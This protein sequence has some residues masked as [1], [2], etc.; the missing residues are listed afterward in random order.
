M[1]DQESG[2]G[3]VAVPLLHCLFHANQLITHVLH[4]VEPA[5]DQVLPH[6]YA[7]CVADN[8]GPIRGIPAGFFIKTSGTHADAAF[9]DVLA[10]F[11]TVMFGADLLAAWKASFLPSRIGL[12]DDAPM[13]EQEMLRVIAQQR[14]KHIGAYE[15]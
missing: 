14:F 3:F 4:E 10:K 1:Q 8:K 11:S 6:T 2:T 15:V 12:S 7:V 13:T 9:L 5:L